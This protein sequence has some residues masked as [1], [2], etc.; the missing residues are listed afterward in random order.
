MDLKIPSYHLSLEIPISP[1]SSHL[2]TRE[3]SDPNY[4]TCSGGARLTGQQNPQN[5]CGGCT[6]LS[7]FSFVSQDIEHIT[8][9]A[10]TEKQ[11]QR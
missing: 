5:P 6:Y 4:T 11:H 2:R 3:H 9:T 10:R 1:R 8:Y 7:H